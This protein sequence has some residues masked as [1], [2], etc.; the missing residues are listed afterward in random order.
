MLDLWFPTQIYKERIADFKE[1]NS[2]L[3]TVVGNLSQ[4]IPCGGA[5]WIGRPYNT[6][7]TWNIVTDEQF[8]L[9]T[10]KVT[11][12][13]TTYCGLLGVDTR[14]NPVK[15]EEGW[16]NIYQ[17]SDF[18][19]YHAH[20]GFKISAVYYIETTENSSIYFESPYHDVNPLPTKLHSAIT[21]KRAEY[22]VEAGQI[23]VFRSYLRHCVPP[24]KDDGTRIS[25]AFNFN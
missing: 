9:I 8:K 7:G 22:K 3:K 13:V 25:L 16:L 6:C 17:H 18:Q 12:A 15:C 10:D 23:I 2:N 24:L 1:I 14:K 4:T 5:A 11:N 20:D 19:E 21:D